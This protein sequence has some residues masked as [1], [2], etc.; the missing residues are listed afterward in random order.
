[1]RTAVAVV[2]VISG[3]VVRLRVTTLVQWKRGIHDS[4]SLVLSWM[5]S[6]ACSSTSL[7]TACHAWSSMVQAEK[8]AGRLTALERLRHHHQLSDRQGKTT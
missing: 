8:V 4:S 2:M 1:M 6:H 3:P 5:S 7:F